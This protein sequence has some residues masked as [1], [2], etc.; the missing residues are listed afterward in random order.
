MEW[1]DALA[2]PQELMHSAYVFKT[3]QRF[4][5]P[6]DYMTFDGGDFC[7]FGRSYIPALQPKSWWYLPPLG[8]LGSSLPVAIA[9]K[10][11]HPDK[12]VV[13]F[14]GDGSFGFNA[15]EFDTAVRHNLALVTVLGN[16]STWGIDAQIQEELY[17]RKVATDL[18]PTRYDMVVKGMG[19][20]GEHVQHP[21]ELDDA[22]KR[23]FMIERPALINVEVQN[24][25][26]PRAQ[27]AIVRWQA[28]Q[29][30]G[31]D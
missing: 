3:V 11:A 29:P 30:H 7:H 23:A 28:R 13:N 8:M 14:T 5:K 20:H 4:L 25:I 31:S 24:A 19:G 17:G 10:L 27:A 22:I 1:F 2:V 12:R 26:S 16:D 15:M 18:L 9:L 6:D 21:D